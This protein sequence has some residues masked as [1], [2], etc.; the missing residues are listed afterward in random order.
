MIDFGKVFKVP[1][2]ESEKTLLIS[3]IEAL[4]LFH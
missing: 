1:S 2:L 4:Y 3:L